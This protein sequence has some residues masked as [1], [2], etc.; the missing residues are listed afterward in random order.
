M[1]A[2]DESTVARDEARQGL[3]SLARVA[4]R[5]VD[6]SLRR[7]RASISRRRSN[8]GT[9]GE[10]CLVL[11]GWRSNAD[12]SA[13]HARRLRLLKR[14]RKASC[15][16]GSEEAPHAADETTSELI[17]GPWFSWVDDASDDTFEN[18]ESERA[19]ALMTAARSVAKFAIEHGPFKC[20]VGFSQGGAMITLLSNPQVLS[21]L[22]IEGG[23]LWDSAVIC[24]GASSSLLDL[25]ATKW[26]IDVRSS[27]SPMPSLHVFGF[28][29]KFKPQGEVLM[30]TFRAYDSED[31]LIRHA[32]YL[33]CGHTLPASLETDTGF[34]A[35]FDAWLEAATEA[36]PRRYRS[37]EFDE[38]V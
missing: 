10:A 26:G 14:F 16:N 1:C 27:A 37:N 17:D 31:Q 34:H 23:Y 3:P 24:C 15:V 8:K 29:D 20:A 19:T 7:M 4:S 11:H 18:L 32:L 35:E 28:Q 22:G 33:D 25:A 5:R 9:D 6:R 2:R 13:L 38:D 30:N 12:V 36:A 21:M